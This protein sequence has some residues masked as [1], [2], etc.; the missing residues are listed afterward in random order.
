MLLVLDT[1][2]YSNTG[3]QASNAAPLGSQVKF[4]EDG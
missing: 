4:A 1:E 2:V 3:D